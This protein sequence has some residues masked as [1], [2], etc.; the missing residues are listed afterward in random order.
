MSI[1]SSFLGFTP[2]PM[3]LVA[4][5]NTFVLPHSRVWPPVYY[6]TGVY[7]FVLPHW[8]LCGHRWMKPVF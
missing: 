4:H 3:C 7:L 2:L 8:V 6:K 1:R 5:V